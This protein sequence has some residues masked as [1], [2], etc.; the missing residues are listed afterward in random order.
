MVGTSA[1]TSS[2]ERLRFLR[3]PRVPLP[4]RGHRG[5][6]GGDRPRRR[7]QSGDQPD[8]GDEQGGPAG[9]ERDHPLDL[10]VGPLDELGSQRGEAGLH[11]A[12]QFGSHRVH[13]AAQFGSHRAHLAAQFGSH[14]V[15]LAA[16]F[17]SHRAHLGAE[18]GAERVEVVVGGDLVPG[19][20][21]QMGHQGVGLLGAE[22]GFELAVQVESGAVVDRHGVSSIG[23]ERGEVGTGNGTRGV[24]RSSPRQASRRGDVPPVTTTQLLVLSGSVLAAPF[25]RVA[26]RMRC[27][28]VDDTTRHIL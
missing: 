21:W 15:H 9:G 22:H 10:A 23:G 17:G 27:H 1:E 11:L 24:Q 6:A 8:E 12:A 4:P 20:R 13:L 7:R 2:L 3:P 14:R 5:G 28:L 16:Q 18:G 19:N 25:V 26:D